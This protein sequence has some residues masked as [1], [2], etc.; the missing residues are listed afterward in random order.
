MTVTSVIRSTRKTRHDHHDRRDRLRHRRVRR[1]TRR[2]TRADQHARRFAARHRR[3]PRGSEVA[4]PARL[5]A[6]RRLP[7]LAPNRRIHREQLIDALWPDAS[8]DSVANRLHKGAHFVRKATGLADSVVLAGDTVAL[9]PN[10]EVATDV[11]TFEHLAVEALVNGD[12][13][14][15]ARAVDAYR[16]DLLPYDLYDDWVAPHRQRLQ[17]RLRELLR[18]SGQFERLVAI[19]PIDEDAHVGMMRAM[20]RAGDRAGVLRQFALL[21]DVLEHELGAEPGPDACS[22]RDLA[23]VREGSGSPIA[24][25]LRLSTRS[26]PARH[27]GTGRRRCRAGAHRA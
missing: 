16:G 26:W 11:A 18:K 9:F 1:R 6:R 14:T 13:E 10:A 24:A 5:D 21:R 23:L 12:T 4:R 27:P 3:P 2:A 20:L 7:A 15:I 22:A 25:G 19:D 17:R 8:F